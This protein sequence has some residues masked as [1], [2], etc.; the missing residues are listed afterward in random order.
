MTLLMRF[1]ALFSFLH[2]ACAQADELPAIH[3]LTD[4]LSVTNLLIQEAAPLHFFSFTQLAGGSM[5]HATATLP[6]T[7]YTFDFVISCGRQPPAAAGSHIPSGDATAA[8]YLSIASGRESAVVLALETS[9]LDGAWAPAPGTTVYC[10]VGPL[11]GGGWW[12]PYSGYEL[13]LAVRLTALRAPTASGAV[14]TRL[15]PGASPIVDTL[16][17]GVPRLLWTRPVRPSHWRV[18]VDPGPYGGV[19]TDVRVQCSTR[20]PAV[21][22]NGSVAFPASPPVQVG[23]SISGGSAN[24]MV[25]LTIPYIPTPESNNWQLGDSIFCAVS[26]ASSNPSR[27]SGVT[28]VISVLDGMYIPSPAATPSPSPT[29]SRTPSPSVTASSSP[30]PVIVTDGDTFTLALTANQQLYA[31]ASYRSV[32][33]LQLAYSPQPGSGRAL[34][35]RLRCA[36]SGSSA[37]GWGFVPANLRLE[38]SPLA[39]T[40]ADPITLLGPDSLNVTGAADAV[41]FY[42][43]PEQWW[44]PGPASEL[45]LLISDDQPVMAPH[46]IRG[47]TLHA[48]VTLPYAAG[49]A[50]EAGYVLEV[51]ALSPAEAATAAAAAA[52]AMGVSGGGGVPSPSP[53]PSLPAS[54][55]L[56]NTSFTG[57]APAPVSHTLSSGAYL[58]Y[59]FDAPRQA[60]Y[61]TAMLSLRMLDGAAPA[62]YI[63]VCVSP[64]GF[65]YSDVNAECHVAQ[66]TCGRCSEASN[67]A[68]AVPVGDALQRSRLYVTVA[69]TLTSSSPPRQVEVSAAYVDAEAAAS[70]GDGSSA[71]ALPPAAVIGVGAAAGALA[72]V[73]LIVGVARCRR[74][75]AHPA[76]AYVS[77]VSLGVGAISLDGPVGPQ[78]HGN[79]SAYVYGR[80]DVM[81]LAANPRPVGHFPRASASARGTAAG[82]G[83]DVASFGLGPGAADHAYGYGRNPY[84]GAAPAGIGYSPG[85]PRKSGSGSLMQ[86]VM[87]FPQPS[88]P[89]GASF[90]GD[91][92]GHSGFFDEPSPRLPSK[93]LSVGQHSAGGRSGMS[94]GMG[95][96]RGA[97]LRAAAQPAPSGPPS[98]LRTAPS[99]AA[100]VFAPLASPAHAGASGRRGTADPVALSGAAAGSGQWSGGRTMFL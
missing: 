6:S 63:S 17:P 86:P 22:A 98:P 5:V 66:R 8:S 1:L 46:V 33:M 74:R 91:P 10:S 44:D 13:D 96:M 9:S 37:S 55:L 81:L 42:Q 19:A 14:Y 24:Q 100:A 58:F 57:P 3:V 29:P 50:E 30:L 39:P 47:G 90:S 79:G 60:R 27:A 95:S 84:S 51:R 20:E 41:I 87:S 2:F 16:R 83:G 61:G 36:S 21:L 31:R 85:V 59:V 64:R 4:G 97:T 73:G 52:A 75:A 23:G 72:L 99:Y 34:Q 67:I 28:A 68:V 82:G 26:H 48:R 45:L 62:T 38:V 43:R 92:G 71:A 69:S 7:A 65:G 93:R 70:A 25:Y 35:L 88:A 80:G 18:D 54:M 11:E 15:F 12:P 77:N 40:L 53:A 49:A 89:A 78:G 76:S 94:S 32:H 56:F